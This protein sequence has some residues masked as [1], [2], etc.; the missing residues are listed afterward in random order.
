MDL[1][2]S[3]YQSILQL[4]S[5][6]DLKNENSYHMIMLGLSIGLCNDYEIISNRE[7]GLGRCDIILKSKKDLPS[8][9][10][11]FKYTK[12]DKTNLDYLANEAIEQIINMK[13]DNE[14]TNKVIYIGLAHC[15][16]KVI[17]KSQER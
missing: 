7:E 5:F 1:F 3:T 2:V 11:E 8:Y 10:L 13:Y 15:G 16:K 14:L 12:N 4:P 9:V 6:Y 17:V